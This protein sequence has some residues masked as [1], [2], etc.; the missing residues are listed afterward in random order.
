MSIRLY[1]HN[2]TAY[3]S[4]R[5]MLQETGKA[6]VIHPTGTGKSFLAFRLIEDLK[7][8][9]FLWLSPSEYIFQTQME[10]LQREDPDFP[11][12]RI[13]FLTYARLLVLTPEDI[14]G[15]CPDVIILDE[16]HRCGARVWGKGIQLLLKQYPEAKVLG[17]SATA[18]RYLDNDRDMAEELFDRNVASEMTLGEA[19]VRGILPAPVYVSAIYEF[20]EELK[21]Y[22]SRIRSLRGKGTREQNQ[23]Y[24]DALRRK[25]E[26]SEGLDVIFSRYMENKAGKYIIFCAN[27][28]HLQKIQELSGKGFHSVDPSPHIYTVYADSLGSGREFADFQADDSDHLKLLYCIDMLNEGVHVRGISGVIL[29]RP[30]VSPIIYKQQ[31]GRALTAGEDQVPLIIDV[32]NNAENL[33]SIDALKEEMSAAVFWMRQNGQS[34]DIIT[35]TFEIKDQAEDCRKLFDKLEAS[36]S[37]TWDQYYQAAKAYSKTHGN[38]LLTMPR[39]YVSPNGL[40]VGSW[41]QT[42]KLVRA[43]RQLGTL[44]KPQIAL[45]DDIGMVWENRL[46]LQFEKNYG[47]ALEYYQ[48]NGDLLVPVAYKTA[49]GFRLGAWINNLR[50]RYANG[51][52]SGML[53]DDHRSRLEALGMQWNLPDYTWE[54]NI[55]EAIRW[56]QTR[57]PLSEGPVKYRTE[58]GFALGMWLQNLRR[59]YQGKGKNRVLTE[60]QI[61]QLEELGM[62]WESRY[63]EMWSKSYLSA[64][65]YFDRYGSV[66]DIPVS[67]T[68]SDGIALGRWI[69]R[70]QAA[71]LHPEEGTTK[72]TARRIRM[73]A[74]IGV[75][76]EELSDPWDQNFEILK[77][78]QRQ[79]GTLDLS[80]EVVH[81]GVW[82]GKW[83]SLQ[84]RAH[85]DGTL[86]PERTARLESIGYDWMSRSERQW[87]ERCREAAEFY[88]QHGNLQVSADRS[89]LRRWLKKQNTRHSNG[90]LK[91]KQVLQLEQLGMQWNS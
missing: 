34:E 23:K 47:Y 76:K 54:K 3:Q 88:Q 29:V 1:R 10:N 63:D 81:Q 51:E 82:I 32:V 80:Q 9:R 87:Q 21:K 26:A 15:L 52:R 33:C 71:L 74:Q 69:R 40:S 56:Y 73:L 17:L 13:T 31:I 18:I 64:K 78:Y 38:S 19:I 90:Q 35:E 50:Q 11:A 77:D 70:Q 55:A 14:E 53:N 25:L 43:G 30:T 85:E 12:E 72:L 75:R 39:R 27:V 91:P 61:R 68:T 28:E 7:D 8:C 20:D 59:S 41:I 22:Q 67:Y 48:T 4:V 62:R 24:L 65:Q 45:L 79:Y 84:K 44:T 37:G 86:T 46:D 83:L 42:Q 57:G 2:Q 60:A 58:N 6:A 66:S 36:L 16:F 89:S 49:D 5:V